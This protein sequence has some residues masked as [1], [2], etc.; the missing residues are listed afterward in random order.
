MRDFLEPVQTLDL[1]DGFDEGRQT[2]VNSE[3]VLADNGCDWKK[4]K[5]VS[6]QFPY[7]SI[8][9]FVLTFH[10][11]AIVLC[12]CSQLMVASNQQHLGRILEL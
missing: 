2:S 9:V 8:A 7:N 5:K 11:E 6:E 10:I 1:V 12:D 4:V 3:N